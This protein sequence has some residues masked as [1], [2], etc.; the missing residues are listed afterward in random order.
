MKVDCSGVKT[1]F[2]SSIVRIEAWHR[3]VIAELPPRVLNGSFE[4]V[5]DLG[6]WPEPTVQ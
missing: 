5:E 6:R 2:L 3:F 1:V 4:N